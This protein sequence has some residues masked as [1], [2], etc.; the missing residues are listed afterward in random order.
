VYPDAEL[1]EKKKPFHILEYHRRCRNEEL[2]KY[3]PYR[4]GLRA[5]DCGCGK[6][7][8]LHQLAGRTKEAWGIDRSAA[9]LDGALAPDQVSTA[10]MTRLPYA[11]ETFDVV[12]GQEILHRARSLASVLGEMARVLRVGGRLILWEP[13]RMLRHAPMADLQ[14]QMQEAGLDLAHTEPFDLVAYPTAIAFSLVPLLSR[15]YLA[16]S[17]A[18]A[19][20]AVDGL[21]GR[22]P[23]LYEH[24]WHLI[25]VA[26]KRAGPVSPRDWVYGGIEINDR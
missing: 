21:L 9:A 12:F 5:L 3:M 26:Q 4:P 7:V 25:L 22:V 17:L 18:K 24:S 8:L 14:G 15:S 20:F 2:I 13:R 10:R 16:Q 23:V 6:G 1:A 19:S 11:E